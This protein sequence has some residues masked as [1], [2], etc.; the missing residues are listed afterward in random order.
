MVENPLI[1]L[2]PLEV[3]S[4]PL[5]ERFREAQRLSTEAASVSN[6]L[7]YRDLVF[8]LAKLKQKPGVD[9]VWT[10][11]DT[12]CG[13]SIYFS[14]YTESS[15]QVYKQITNVPIDELFE[16]GKD[17]VPKGQWSY[18][19]A[20]GL[21]KQVQGDQRKLLSDKAHK[22]ADDQYAD[23]PDLVTDSDS[24][25]MIEYDGSDDDEFE[26]EEEEYDDDTDTDDDDHMR[27]LLR[28][29]MDAASANPDLIEKNAEIPKQ[30]K[31][32][33]LLKALKNL[34]GKQP[35]VRVVFT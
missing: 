14:N 10:K 20:N 24:S 27:E 26:S 19:L 32:N 7:R 30:Y 33:G 17:R 5:M 13:T 23:L 1:N 2:P 4:S 21:P 9:A 35:Y 3:K 28:E 18:N 11:V 12:V 29:C 16:L 22:R 34:A 8:P 6:A 31:T 25:D 15:C